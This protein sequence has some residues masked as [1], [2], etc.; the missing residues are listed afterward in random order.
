M[1]EINVK[2]LEEYILSN[3][4]NENKSVEEKAKIKSSPMFNIMLYALVCYD[5][6]QVEELTIKI[7]NNQYKV[8]R[9]VK[10]EQ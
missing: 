8:K 10:E 5:K 4:G 7:K 6:K 2:K 3:F 1:N 9:I